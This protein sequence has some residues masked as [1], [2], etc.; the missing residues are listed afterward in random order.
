MRITGGKF[1]GRKILAGFASHVRPSTDFMRESLFNLLTHRYLIEESS[2]LDLFSGSGVVSLEFLSRECASVSSV[3]RDN[4]NIQTQKTLQTLF[5]VSNW[6]IHKEDAF[7]F[8]KN[9]HGAPFDFIFADPPYDL[10]EI[11]NLP[12]LTIPHL[13]DQGVMILEHRRGMS[14]KASPV[15]EKKYGETHLSFFEKR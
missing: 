14:F 10:P 11:M 7:R 5:E 1:K 4:K 13:S 12:E 6:Q 3:D 15:L 9:Y 8:L 2:V